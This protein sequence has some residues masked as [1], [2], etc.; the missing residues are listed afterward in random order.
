MPKAGVMTIVVVLTSLCVPASA[1]ASRPVST[2][3]L[4]T[5]LST[6]LSLFAGPL[7]ERT[8]TLDN[9]T[10]NVRTPFLP[11]PEFTAAEPGNLIQSASSFAPRP[12][13]ELSIIAVPFGTRPPAES[14]STNPLP[15]AQKGRAPIYRARL[16]EYAAPYSRARATRAGPTATLFG[17]S[18]PSD[19]ALL[20][21]PLNYVD[22]VLRPALSVEW[23]V[24][25]GPR[26]WIVQVV[27]ELPMGTVDL[28]GEGTFFQALEELSLASD[29]LD[30]KTTVILEPRAA[31][32]PATP[33][34][35]TISAGPNLPSTGSGAGEGLVPLIFAGLGGLLMTGGLAAKRRA[36]MQ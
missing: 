23:V 4:S 30:N 31:P 18:T 1:W 21:L 34:T 6:S 14:A 29:T 10:I 11:G 24:E 12:Y 16:R 25:A 35:P 5:S 32:T 17:Q 13:S 20:E 9:V 28:S 2:P 36:V 33:A 22:G 7:Q 26:L 19:A 3:P 8:I 27:R 15:S